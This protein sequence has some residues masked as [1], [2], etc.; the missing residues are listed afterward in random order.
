MLNMLNCESVWQRVALARALLRDAPVL[1][2]DEATSALD[3]Y[4]V[5]QDVC[6]R[7]CTY[8][9]CVC[10][11]EHTCMHPCIHARTHVFIRKYIHTYV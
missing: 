1:L 7:A 11:H 9:M 4:T 10:V 6:V 5:C 3:V 2:C 8:M